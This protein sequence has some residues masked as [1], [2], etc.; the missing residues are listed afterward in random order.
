MGLCDKDIDAV[1]PVKRI[2]IAQSS[3]TVIVASALMFYDGVAAYSALMGGMIYAIAN[4]YSGRRIFLPK[5][6]VSAHGE[7]NSFYR[8]EIGKLVMIVALCAAVF[9]AVK[10]INIV[11]FVVGFA[12]VIIAGVIG[13]ATQPLHRSQQT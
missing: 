5:K 4:A 2:F 13:A 11:A 8:A 12:V 1:S 7:L 3:V 9:A 10:P 6:E